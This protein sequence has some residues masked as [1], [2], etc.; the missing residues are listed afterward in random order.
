MQTVLR[1]PKGGG[2]ILWS[3]DLFMACPLL[4]PGAVTKSSASGF[5]LAEPLSGIGKEFS[6][7]AVTSTRDRVNH[8]SY[9][10]ST[11]PPFNTYESPLRSLESELFFV[12][13]SA[14]PCR[15]ARSS[16][17]AEEENGDTWI[18]TRDLGLMN[19]SL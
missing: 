9:G 17:A 8:K 11:T 3:P 14:A 19:P 4:I 1:Q 16:L 6:Q 2:I 12:V 10:G 15:E 13:F 7:N 5:V 18:R